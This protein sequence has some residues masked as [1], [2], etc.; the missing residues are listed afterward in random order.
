MPCRR[1]LI[2]AEVLNFWPS[3]SAVADSVDRHRGTVQAR[4]ILENDALRHVAQL[5]AMNC[6]AIST[7][8]QV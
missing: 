2:F 7:V 3:C 4:A 1:F 5:P 8:K 6:R